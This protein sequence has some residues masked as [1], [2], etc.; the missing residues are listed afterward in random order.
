MINVSAQKSILSEKLDKS[1]VSLMILSNETV[2]EAAAKLLQEQEQRDSY[3]VY[4]TMSRPHSRVSNELEE[5][6]IDTDKI[7]YIDGASNLGGSSA[8][9]S[10]NVI[11]L[12]PQQ[13][14]QISIAI[15]NAVEAI[16][17]DESLL[18]FDAISTLK[19]YNEKQ[20]ISK[21]AHSL[22][23]Q[24]GKWEILS[25]VMTVTEETDD[26]LK[27]QLKQFSDSIVR[28]EEY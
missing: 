21:F 2:A 4:V 1:E 9:K 18:V 8:K 12:K 15:S 20:Q 13:L 24:L 6:G 11:Y 26:E 3:T 28:P 23:S 27:S 14:T 5:K 25:V 22:M 10:E 16:E 19:I 7:F 17:D